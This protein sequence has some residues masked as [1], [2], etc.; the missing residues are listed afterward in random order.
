[1]PYLH[2]LIELSGVASN[3]TYSAAN[4]TILGVIDN[5]T[6]TGDNDNTAT[7]IVELNDTDY[8]GGILTIGGV[9]Y[10][11]HLVTPASTSQP[12]TLTDGSGAIRNV[13]G[14][15][16]RT[17]IAFIR[18]VPLSGTGATRY[19]A[20]LDDSVGDI[21]IASLQTRT[22]DFDPSGHDVKINLTTNN[23][24]TSDGGDLLIGGDGND[25]LNG[26]GGNDTLSGGAG[27]DTLVGGAGNDRL[28]GGIGNDHL[29]GGDGNDTLNGDD[30][31]DNLYGGA[32]EDLLS[33]G[34]GN[35]YVHGGAGH[36]TL[37]GGAGHDTLVGDLGNDVL[38]GGLGND[39]LDGGSGNDTLNG[40]DGDDYLAGGLGED[41]LNGGAGMDYLDGGDGHD[42]LNGGA[43]NDTVVGGLGNDL[44]NGGL[45]NDRLDGG[46]GNDTLNGD[47]GD[48]SLYGGTGE[49][50]LDGGAGNDYLDGGDGY[51]TLNGGAGHD[52]LVGGLGSDLLNGGL[53]NDRLDGG[54]GNDTLNGEDGDDSLY[55]GANEDL[56]DGGLGND[57]LE[58]GDG[59]DTLNGGTGQDT[60]MGGL[61]NDLLNGG[62][63]NDVLDGGA[64]NDTLNGGTGADRLTGG[65]GN[66]VFVYT[67]DGSIDRITDFNTGNT[68]ALS[69]GDT[70]NNDFIDL[71]RYYHSLSQLKADHAD[72]GILNQS[73]TTDASG[74]PV[75]YDG[76]ESLLVNGSGGIVFEGLQPSD[77][78]NDNTG[79][80]CFVRGTMIL[81]PD[82]EVPVQDLR[83]GDL[84]LTLDA[85]AQPVLWIGHRALSAAELAARPRLRPIRISAGALGEG[86]PLRALTVSPQHRVLLRSRIAGRMFGQDEV[87]VAAKHLVGSCGIEVIQDQAP[88]EYWHVMFD[89]HQVICS[90][91]AMTESLFTGAEALDSMGRVSRQEIMELLPQLADRPFRPARRFLNGRAGRNL[92]LRHRKNQVALCAAS[93]LGPT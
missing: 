65:S 25:A 37:N 50:L 14:D 79:V 82:G 92:A 10:K 70:T 93:G 34:A 39:H 67:A 89:R 28:D 35:D 7:S 88:V 55:G 2:D 53:G 87:L 21:N 23:N 74:R 72:D 61:G 1:M 36:D 54:D 16:Y 83:R 26:G 42:T 47:D 81:T 40:D 46:D 84:V 15:D 71:S 80:P 57:Y 9:A 18:A 66:D 20:A 59:H 60:L 41:V 43:D 78:T 45:G 3:T 51:D 91:G 32:G 8:N 4:G 29:D 11:I 27:A 17:N 19:F 76:K 90:E 30:G 31:D 56:L 13:T 62:A 5:S 33:G 6:Y 75:S 69:D 73:N 12:V 22:L 85:G 77:F 86:L 64:G 58:G 63:D 48:D 24:I 49:D 52:T 68:G 44:L 38:N